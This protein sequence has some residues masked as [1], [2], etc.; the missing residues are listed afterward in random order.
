KDTVITEEEIEK[1]LNLT[2]ENLEKQEIIDKDMKLIDHESI[3]MSPA[4]VHIENNTDKKVRETFEK[5]SE[6]NIYSIGRYGAW[7]YC[8]MEDCMLQAKE[9]FEKISQK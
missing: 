5:L 6:D 2:L 3:I 4:Y 1:Q 7:T 9:L 8:S